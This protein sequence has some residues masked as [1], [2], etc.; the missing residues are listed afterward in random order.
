M[1]RSYEEPPAA[2]AHGSAAV[3]DRRLAW[4]LNW[5]VTKM[6]IATSRL[7]G[8]GGAQPDRLRCL[9][10]LLWG[11]GNLIV[12]RRGDVPVILGIALPHMIAFSVLVAIGIQ[13]V[14][15]SRAIV[16]GYT[17]PLWVIPRPMLFLGEP[18]TR[19]HVPVACVGSR[20]IGSD[21]QSGFRSTGM[22]GVPARQWLAASRLRMLGRQ[23]RLC[24]R[25]QLGIDAVPARLLGGASGDDRV[26]CSACGSMACL[27]VDWTPSLA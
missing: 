2:A 9:L 5:P 17:T 1:L 24:A 13:F 3:L 20:R 8:R 18:I 22:T 21:V 23:H 10:G 7:V 16:L 12:P 11:Q 6:I 14:P 19:R 15:A 25:P 26:V 27:D 4:G